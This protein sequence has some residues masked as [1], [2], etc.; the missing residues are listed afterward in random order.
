MTKIER[1][2]KEL[3]DLRTFYLRVKKRNVPTEEPPISTP[4]QTER[5]KPTYQLAD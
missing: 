3:S 2:L 5:K 4:T 1:T